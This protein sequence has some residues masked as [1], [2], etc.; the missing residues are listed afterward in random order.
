MCAESGLL[1]R[2]L[3]F[4]IFLVYVYCSAILGDAL[5]SLVDTLWE[6]AQRARTLLGSRYSRGEKV[7]RSGFAEAGTVVTLRVKHKK[8]ACFD[9][10]LAKKIKD[11]LFSF[12]NLLSTHESKDR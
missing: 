7:G 10:N 6:V 2:S 11:P 4:S 3:D 5:Q 1:A 8:D 9:R 12:T